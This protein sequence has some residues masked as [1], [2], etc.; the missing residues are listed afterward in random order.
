MKDLKY[1][2]YKPCIGRKYRAIPKLYRPFVL[3]INS[4]LCND[5]L[6]KK[7]KIKFVNQ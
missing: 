6:L 2:P 7:N 1:N 3:L 4:N 5:Y